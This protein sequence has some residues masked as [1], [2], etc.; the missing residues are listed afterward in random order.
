[1]DT[2]AFVKAVTAHHKQYG[3]HDLPWRSNIGDS[4]WPYRVLV[5]E[6]MLQQTQVPRVVPKFTIFLE[7]FKT[8]K[9]LAAAELSEVL[10]LW[11]GLGYNRRAKFLWESAGQVVHHHNADVPQDPAE[12]VRLPGVGVNTA[13][14]VAV[15]AYNQPHVFVETNIRTVFVYHFF[16]GQ[17]QV[18]DASVIQ[19]VRETLPSHNPREWYWALMDYG[20]HLKKTVGNVARASAAYTRQPPFIGSQR[21]VRGAVLRLLTEQPLSSWELNER[22]ADQRLPDVLLALTREG[23]VTQRSG[24]YWL[25][26]SGV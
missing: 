23:L 13:A 4:T 9:D 25:G 1:M 3:R 26:G 5:S 15:Y 7:R 16:A 21:Q 19:L 12:L 24:R 2:S 11:S 22:L 17:Q 6:M 10:G 20:T 14:A 18:S 8:I